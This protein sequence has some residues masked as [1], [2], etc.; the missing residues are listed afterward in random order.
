MSQ[1]AL[2]NERTV[3]LLCV[4]INQGFWRGFGGGGG[5]FWLQRE[6]LTFISPAA[7]QNTVVFQI[8]VNRIPPN[9]DTLFAMSLYVIGSVK[10]SLC[11][12]FRSRSASKGQVKV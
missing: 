8:G 1:T 11:D 3:P 4:D 10:G 7:Y 12:V 2:L 6:T 5:P 9:F